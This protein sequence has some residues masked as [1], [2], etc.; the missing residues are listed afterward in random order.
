MSHISLSHDN[1][2]CA[3]VLCSI[4]ILYISLGIRCYELC[5]LL[6]VVLV[7]SHLINTLFIACTAPGREKCSTPVHDYN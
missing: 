5:L 2:D 4:E 3:A 1:C 6:P 7:F